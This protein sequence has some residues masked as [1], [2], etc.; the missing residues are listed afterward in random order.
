MHI[1]STLLS[2]RNIFKRCR[3]VTITE[4]LSFPHPYPFLRYHFTWASVQNL[5]I[6]EHVMYVIDNLNSYFIAC[7]FEIS[8]SY[9]SSINGEHALHPPSCIPPYIE[10]TN[11]LYSRYHIWNV[12]KLLFTSING[13]NWPGASILTILPEVTVQNYTLLPALAPISTSE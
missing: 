6:L 4:F 8:W 11:I 1:L 9:G 7:D 3:Y 2:L 13:L 5:Q 10:V 12:L